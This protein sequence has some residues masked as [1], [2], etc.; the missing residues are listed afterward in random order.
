M[1][2]YSL[3]LYVVRRWGSREG[4]AWVGCSHY[5]VDEDEE[6]ILPL[7]KNEMMIWR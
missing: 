4:A 3:S 7:G 5:A 2:F 6:K 1:D